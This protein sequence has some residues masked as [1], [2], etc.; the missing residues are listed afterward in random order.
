M[1]TI[2]IDLMPKQ[3]LKRKALK[4]INIIAQVALVINMSMLGAII[5][6]QETGAVSNP[7]ADLDQCANDPAPSP[8]T[9]GCSTDA[10]EWVNG[11]L[12]ASKSVYYEGDSVPYRMKFDNLTLDS[13]TV[14]IEWD[15]TKSGKHAL[16][17]ITTYNQ[18]VATADP[19]L[20][21][22]GL[23]AGTT[24]P[25]PNDPQVTGAGVT[26]IAG[27][28]T[29]F[30]GTITAASAYTYP[31]GAGFTGDKS[32]QITLT[33]TASV[34][35]PV[36]AWG[37]H[38]S[39]R[40]D[41]GDENSA[42]T[43]PGSPYHTR[44]IGLDGSGGNQDRS[45]SAQAVV[46]PATITVVKDAIP[47]GSQ[48]FDYTTTGGLAP[49]SFSLVDDGTAANTQAFADLI[50]FTTYTVTESA[51]AGWTLNGI[52]C[53]V[54]SSNGGSQTVNI[55]AVSID[56]EEG[57]NVTC[58]YTNERLPGSISGYKWNDLNGNGVWD[59]GEPG[60]PGWTI[61]LGGDAT[62]S[63][64]TA[65]DGSYLFT[66]LNPGDYTVSETQQN[67]W[68]Q[69]Y[70]TGNLH[71][72]NLVAGQNVTDVNFGN[73]AGQCELTIVKSV[74]NLTHP[75]GP[76]MPG[77]VLEYTLN[78][79]NIGDADC[80]GTGVKIYDELHAYLTYNGNH[81]QDNDD[82]DITYH[83]NFSWDFNSPLANAHVVSP[84][85]T[86]YVTFEAVITLP[87]ECGEFEIPNYAKIW[88]NETGYM[89]SNTVYT[90][91]NIPCRAT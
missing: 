32:A 90:I 80:T 41:W 77:D 42:V 52:A 39:D 50:N 36:L 83:G 49:A 30:G 44:L 61:I 71:N 35:N 25:I 70:P 46:F 9:D 85:E 16:D 23:P 33:F 31:D 20:G 58:T 18:T 79:E 89:T 21:V 56:L 2:K 72:V 3:T 88:S 1:N 64:T 66:N 84:G 76:N 29:L 11:N 8:S 4:T 67:N 69:T 27:D 40:A 81:S 75:Q 51:P 63:T 68:I 73:R 82:H 47:N 15:T 7:S 34:A 48:S 55:P 91:V 43:I 38:I 59:Q 87:D 78:Y 13:H 86:G 5:V 74:V 28:F 37:G 19:T 26:P 22:S 62:D 60:L 6:P 65:Q 53:V 45:L 57:E 17:Y 24:F 12:G 14:T 10:S 54:T